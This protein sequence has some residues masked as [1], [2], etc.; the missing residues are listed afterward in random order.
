[1]FLQ[2][3]E[4]SFDILVHVYCIHDHTVYRYGPGVN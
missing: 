2:L 3:R 4:T 1:M